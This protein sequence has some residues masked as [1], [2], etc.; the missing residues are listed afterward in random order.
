MKKVIALILACA[1]A[2][3]ACA[4]TQSSAA[5]GETSTDA[6]QA[7]E[8]TRVTIQHVNS[9]ASSW[10]K[11]LEKMVEKVNADSNGKYILELYGN[12]AL[13]QKDPDVMLEMLQSGSGQLCLESLTT[14]VSIVPDLFGLQMPFLFEDADHLTRFINSNPEILQ[15]WKEQFEEKG[16]VLLG[17]IPRDFR[18]LS[19]KSTI[20]KTPE[21][22]QGLKYRVPNNPWYVK[23]FEC[24]GAKPVPISSSE[25]YTAIQLGTVV[26]ED[27]AIPT[28]YDWKFYEV[29]P[30]TTVW[31][32]MAD[33]SILFA[34]KA[35]WDGLSEEDQQLFL[36]AG[37]VA[38][39]E[40]VELDVSY[41][42]EAQEAMEAAGVT[43]YTM[44][45]E[46]KDAFRELVTPVYEEFAAEIGQ[47]NWDLLVQAVEDTKQ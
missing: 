20:I 10:E 29:E 40:I 23:T 15:K 3:S 44:T 43:F 24:F 13:C 31:N 34:N 22:I 35:F 14:L 32:Y 8:A 47:E 39:D 33:A 21:D 45:E 36:E 5:S 7:A 1:M 2:L 42:V 37:Q 25:V 18:Q 19:N 46:E 4:S 17:I 6:G 27:N 26:G 30:Y 12:G 11:G 9:T 38:L 41:A 28:V 16:L